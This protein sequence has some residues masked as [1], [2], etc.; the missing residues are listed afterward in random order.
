MIYEDYQNILIVN[1]AAKSREFRQLNLLA[2]N[3]DST[4]L[5]LTQN[6]FVD[7]AFTVSL[8]GEGNDLIGAGLALGKDHLYMA[9][10]SYGFN[11]PE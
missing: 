4:L 3:Y 1:I 7:R 6:G 5:F 8:N 2:N 10:M 11:T 9:G